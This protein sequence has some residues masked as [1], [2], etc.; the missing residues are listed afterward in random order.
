[1]PDIRV[2]K[3]S[4]GHI[5]GENLADLPCYPNLTRIGRKTLADPSLKVKGK[6]LLFVK[7]TIA[8]PTPHHLQV[9]NLENQNG[10]VTIHVEL[11]MPSFSLINSKPG[12]R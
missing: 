3:K 8:I 10:Y 11:K 4:M 2:N 9:I 6:V 5:H 7:V 12:I 1:M